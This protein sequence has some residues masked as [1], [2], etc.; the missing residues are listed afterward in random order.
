MALKPRHIEKLRK[1]FEDGLMRVQQLD[2]IER[3]QMRSK[4]RREISFV[5]SWK[6]PKAEIII[7]R[8][9]SRLSDVFS[10]FPHRFK[11]DLT[12][13]LQEIIKEE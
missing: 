10:L 9:E 3:M 6:N 2:R 1:I 5:S 13:L 8:W 4:I 7:T 11:D 12:M